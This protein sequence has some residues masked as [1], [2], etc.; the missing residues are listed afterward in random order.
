M[1]EQATTLRP[2]EFGRLALEALA[3]AEGR[4]KQRKRDQTPDRI[5]LDLK[6]EILQ[7]AV[8]DDPAPEDFEA[9]LLQ[10]ALAADASGPIR[11]V[12]GMIMDE[13][14]M[15]LV[16]PDF[17]RWLQQGAP[18]DDAASERPRPDTEVDPRARSVPSN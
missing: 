10:Q 2:S 12:C 9:W 6:R 11:A 1:T 17:S 5:G 4:R 8:A 3:A 15:A 14:R 7:R 13:Y 18:S 16:D